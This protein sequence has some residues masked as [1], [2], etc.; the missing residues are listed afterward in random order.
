MGTKYG[1]LFFVILFFTLSACDET[2][3][4]KPKG[5]P[6]IKL[7][8]KQYVPFI[9]NAPFTFEYPNYATIEVDSNTN[10]NKAEN[11]Y[12]YDINF[13]QLN[14]RLHLSYKPINKG[15]SV[16]KLIEDAYQLSF[17]HSVKAESIDKGNIYVRPGVSGQMFFISGNAASANQFYLTDST[18]HFVRGALYFYCPPNSDSLN[19]VL[20]FIQ[21]DID[22]FINSF[23]WQ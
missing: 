22:H 9:S 19:P 20:R 8:T 11:P 15:T 1:Y 21:A 14:A 13:G 3:T 16:Q 17:K 10:Y 23:N 12:W 2:Y 4:P 7:P 5:Y 6:R 18:K